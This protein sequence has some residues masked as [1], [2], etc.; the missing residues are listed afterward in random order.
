MKLP[1]TLPPSAVT[2]LIDTREQMPL[3]LSPLRTAPAALATGDYTVAGLEHVVVIER[4]SLPDLIGVVGRERERF[5]REVQR[6][7]AFPVRILLIES[8]WPEI[9][10]GGWR[11][12]VTTEAVVGSL[13]G[14]IA[15]G[16]QVELVG[17]HDRAGRFAARILYTVARRR[18]RELR[19]LAAHMI[20]PGAP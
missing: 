16:I 15:S 4:K 10:A 5:D 20:T 2:A 8:T 14:W 6:M 13:L 19:A 3:D 18:W 12:N 7:L 1:A 17:D 11:G 9:E